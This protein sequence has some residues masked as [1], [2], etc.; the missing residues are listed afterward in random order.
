MTTATLDQATMTSAVEMFADGGVSVATAVREYGLS[1]SVLYAL[2]GGGQL[3]YSQIGRKR[4]LAR[5]ALAALLARSVVG[6]APET[7]NAK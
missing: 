3:P 6:F 4:I 1:R 7:A 5:R 2:M